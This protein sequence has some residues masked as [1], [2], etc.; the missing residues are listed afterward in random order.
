MLQRLRLRL[1]SPTTP[2]ILAALACLAYAPSLW[3]GWAADDFLHAAV[4]DDPTASAASMFDAGQLERSRPWWTDPQWRASFLR[5]LTVLTHQLDHLLWPASPW[6]MHLVSLAWYAALVLAVGALLRAL[7]Q[8]RWAMILALWMFALDDAHAPAVSWIAARGSILA[9]TFGTV[10]L[11]LHIRARRRARPPFAAWLWF[12]LALASSE[13]AISQL[14]YLAAY[15]VV[16]EPERRRRAWSIAPYFAIALAW[17]TAHALLGY[18]TAGTGLYIQPWSEPLQFAAVLLPRT[19]LMVASVL[20]LPL[21][22]DPLAYVAGAQLLA[23]VVAVVGLLALALVVRPVLR[24]DAVARFFALATVLCAAPLAATVPQDRHALL[25]GIGAFG[26]VS[27]VLVVLVDGATSSRMLRALAWVWCVLHGVL[28][29]LLTPVRAWTP[30]VLRQFTESCADALPDD[31]TPPVVL[32]AAPSDLHVMYTRALRDVEAR[33]H[34]ERFSTLYTGAF[35]VEV[36]RVGPRSL[37][38][39]TPGWFAA[40]MAQVFRDAPL[41]AGTQITTAEFDADIVTADAAGHPT[42][43]RFTFPCVLEQCGIVWLGW[44]GDRAVPSAPPSE[45]A[46]LTIAAPW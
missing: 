31:R 14:G 45:G 27:R 19:A 16:L 12:A 13:V 41:P 4:L 25:L 30:A 34:P 23:G 42:A 22:L 20:G 32:F 39:R 2:W 5:P 3:S 44:S 28:G 15:A 1:A 8:P 18:G 17:L 9:A 24:N 33:P 7:G 26:L 36:A 29:P 6:A 37:E 46:A 35:P 11:T 10:A 21:L 40:P 38:L 43:V